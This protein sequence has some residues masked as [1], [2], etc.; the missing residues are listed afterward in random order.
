MMGE[1]LDLKMPLAIEACQEILILAGQDLD[2]GRLRA[3][4]AQAAFRAGI[5]LGD[6]QVAELW[7]DRALALAPGNA[8]LWRGKGNLLQKRQAWTKALAAYETA[9]SLKPGNPVF[10]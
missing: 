1:V 9:V 3:D 2:T 10:L 5:Q 6:S 4:L 7:L 8:T